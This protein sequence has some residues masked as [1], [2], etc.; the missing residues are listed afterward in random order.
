MKRRSSE[1]A[2]R[3]GGTRD[4]AALPSRGGARRG[5]AKARQREGEAGDAARTRGERWRPGTRGCEREL[6]GGTQGGET[7]GEETEGE[8][9]RPGTRGG[10]H[11]QKS[12]RGQIAKQG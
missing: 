7:E 1:K 10:R 11:C 4:E 9:G 12:R 3:E 6:D 5:S 2:R 8:A